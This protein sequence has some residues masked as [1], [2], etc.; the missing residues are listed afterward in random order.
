MND[1]KIIQQKIHE[2]RG[3]RVMLD[4]DLVTLYGVETGVLN[5]AVK[6]NI[7]RFP[8]DFMFQLTKAEWELLKSHTVTLNTSGDQQDVVLISQNVISSWGGNM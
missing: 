3:Q 5:Q 8:E 6:R 4:Y 2:I 7:E 1:V